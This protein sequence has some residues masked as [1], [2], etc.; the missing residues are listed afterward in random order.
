VGNIE[1]AIFKHCGQQV[2]IS[3]RTIH[4]I[5]HILPCMAIG[6]NHRM[7]MIF[8]AVDTQI[9]TALDL[10]AQWLPCKEVT[11]L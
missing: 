3:H 2:A 7:G 6:S 5:I 1:I 8:V 9:H 10:R 4:I 11:E